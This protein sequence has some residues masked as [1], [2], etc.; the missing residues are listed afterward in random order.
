[1]PGANRTRP[2]E[3]QNVLVDTVRP[4]H[5]EIPEDTQAVLTVSR[6]P[7]LDAVLCHD[8]RMR[9][10]LMDR[11]EQMT[12]RAAGVLHEEMTL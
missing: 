1:L 9:I 10:E 3:P 7:H 8:K 6:V 2:S 5:F 12:N 4:E 11:R